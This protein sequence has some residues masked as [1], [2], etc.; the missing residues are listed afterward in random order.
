MAKKKRKTAKVELAKLMTVPATSGTTLSIRL[1]ARQRHFIEEAARKRGGS[2]TNFIK[3]AAIEKAVHIHNLAWENEF[4]F[5]AVAIR[6]AKLLAGERELWARDGDGDEVP[7]PETVLPPGFTV[8]PRTLSYGELQDL[9]E[10]LR[11]GGA[12]FMEEVCTRVWELLPRPTNLK[13]PVCPDSEL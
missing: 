10:G 8:L 11:L 2:P 6:L 12:E 5:R 1:D 4:N 9:Q 13:P 3:V 7:V